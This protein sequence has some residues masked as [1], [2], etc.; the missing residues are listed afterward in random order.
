MTELNRIEDTKPLSS[1]AD[2]LEKYTSEYNPSYLQEID[3]ASLPE[4]LQKVV[5]ILKKSGFLNE[6]EYEE[7]GQAAKQELREAGVTVPSFAMLKDT[8]IMSLTEVKQ[9]LK[10]KGIMD[11]VWKKI[12]GVPS[13][14]RIADRANAVAGFE[15]PQV[16]KE[17]GVFIIYQ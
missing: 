7:Y 1:V 16:L 3:E 11:S 17:G 14:F 2:L 13:R 15:R 4:N 8:Q 9:K 6:D 10:E 5:S 12:P